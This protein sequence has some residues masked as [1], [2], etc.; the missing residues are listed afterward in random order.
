MFTSM[1]P[2]M[3]FAPVITILLENSVK[4]LQIETLFLS[5]NDNSGQ[6]FASLWVS[7]SICGKSAIPPVAIFENKKRIV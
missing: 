3:L 7:D 1:K 4:V 2:A 5:I 6:N